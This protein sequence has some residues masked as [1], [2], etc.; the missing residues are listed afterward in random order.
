M[1]WS[2]DRTAHSFEIPHRRQIFPSSQFFTR[3]VFGVV[4]DVVANVVIVVVVVVVVGAVVVK[5][6]SVSSKMYIPGCRTYVLYL[7]PFGVL[8]KE[9]IISR[10][11][12]D[13]A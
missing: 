11:V 5:F 1:F 12:G 6:Q 13:E 10:C 2:F 9:K 3:V 7:Y 8:K 4:L